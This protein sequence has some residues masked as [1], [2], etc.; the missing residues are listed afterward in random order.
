MPHS[1]FLHLT[2]IA[3]QFYV[4]FPLSAP[5][6]SLET[7]TD[8]LMQ[9]NPKPRLPRSSS[10]PGPHSFLSYPKSLQADI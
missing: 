3:S 6:S 2:H 5:V 10:P 1:S 8:L 7:N 9:K 4:I